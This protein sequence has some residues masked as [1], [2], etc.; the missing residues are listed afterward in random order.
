MHVALLIFL[1]IIG[2]PIIWLIFVLT[3]VKIIRKIHQF[4]IPSFMIFFIDNPIRRKYWQKPE[5]IADRMGAKPGDVIVEV[6][7][8][9]GSYTIAVAKRVQP[10]GKV[11][12]I[13]IQQSVID[14]LQKRLV[15]EGINNIVPKVDDAYNLSFEDESVDIIFAITCLPEIPEPVRVLKEF[16]RILKPDGLVSLCELFIDPDY[17]LRKTEKKWV[18]EAGLFVKEEYGNWFS[19]QLNLC[20]Q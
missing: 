8:G 3:V 1:V 13:D 12:T 4:P 20:K 6:G 14:R 11:Y 2:I 5:E 7:P 18:T 19:Y 9:K 16:K 15:K 17:P 10:N